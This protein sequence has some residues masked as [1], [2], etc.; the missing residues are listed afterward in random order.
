[1]DVVILNTSFETVK[2]LDTFESFIWTERFSEYGDFELYLPIEPDVFDYIKKDY[3]VTIKDS[4]RAMIIE[5]ISIDTDPDDGA[6][7]Q[8]T[9]RSLESLLERR[10]VWKQTTL[11]GT[12]Q[13]GIK[14]LL[15]ENVVSPSDSNRKISE[16][17]FASSSD[18]AITSLNVS[19]QFTGDNLYDVIKYLCDA[20]KIGFKVTLESINGKDRFA[21]RLYPGVDRS[22]EQIENPYVV[23][24]PSYENLITSNYL[25]SDRD[26]KTVALVAGTGEGENRLAATVFATTSVKAGISRREL[27]VDAKDIFGEVDG[28]V[29][30]NSEYAQLLLQRGREKLSECISVKSFEAEAEITSSVYTYGVDYDIGDI[31]EMANSYGNSARARIT[32]VVR[33][34][35]ETGYSVYPTFISIE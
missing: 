22:Y 3:Y 16:F 2:V 24:S 32:E 5:T 13:N 31:V 4:K 27:Y 15:D 17:Y 23:F 20:Y 35:S 18:A 29:I 10:I 26:L 19:A 21:F 33:S 14:K 34:E 9:G 1:M 25:E 8:V 7:L 12:L 30:S 6:T 28:E 11:S